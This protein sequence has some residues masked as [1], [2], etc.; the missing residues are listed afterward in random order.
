VYTEQKTAPE[1]TNKGEETMAIQFDL[2]ALSRFSNVNFGDNDAIANLGEGNGLVQNEKL[3]FI[4][5]RKFRSAVAERQNNAVRTELLKSLGRAFNLTG[6]NEANGTF[7]DQFMRRLEEILGRDT[8]KRGD[9]GIKNGVVDSGKPLTQRRIQAVYNA[10]KTY[11]A[12]VKFQDVSL[13]LGGAK[14]ADIV[15]GDLTDAGKEGVK[16]LALLAAKIRDA[17]Q[18]L[19]NEGNSI[20]VEQGN[21]MVNLALENGLIK[22]SAKIGDAEAKNV[23]NFAKT[24]DDLVQTM[25]DTI[26]ALYDSFPGAV[27]GE[28]PY[29]RNA[30]WDIVD[31][32]EKS[33]SREDLNSG[34]DCRLREF[35]GGLLKTKAGITE[36]EIAKLTNDDLATLSKK[37]LNTGDADGVRNDAAGYVRRNVLL[38]DQSAFFRGG[39]IG[40]TAGDKQ[41]AGWKDKANEFASLAVE[42]REAA[43]KMTG[44]GESEWIVHDDFSFR[45]TWDN[46][47][48][49]VSLNVDGNRRTVG[50]LGNSPDEL[51]KAMDDAIAGLCDSPEERSVLAETVLESYKEL[52]DDKMDATANCPLRRF[53]G[54]LLMSKAGFAEDQIKMFTNAELAGLV[55][56]LCEKG[57]VEEVRN[58]AKAKHEKTSQEVSALL[59]GRKIDE[60]VSDKDNPG[61][62]SKVKNLAVLAGNINAAAQRLHK[63]GGTAVAE[64]L[65]VKVELTWGEAGVTAKTTVGGVAQSVE[66]F[67]SKPEDVCDA[68]EGTIFALYDSFPK[69]VPGHDIGPL[70]ARRRN[71]RHGKVNVAG[72]I[73]LEY[74]LPPQ[75]LRRRNPDVE[76]RRHDGAGRQSHEQTA[77]RLRQGALQVRRCAGGQRRHRLCHGNQGRACRGHQGRACRGQQGCRIQ[78]PCTRDPRRPGQSPGR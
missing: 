5:T 78:K 57:D 53:A 44:R 38:D 66:N 52:S 15:G 23:E 48:M 60:I 22:A 59:G 54:G 35:A 1:T 50:N 68:M 4:L 58:E 70:G 36:A 16:H 37:L 18:S 51:C 17:A 9:F 11:A 7:T 49:K 20:S 69:G 10:A 47:G 3:G 74:R 39:K 12:N 72:G 29:G 43:Q 21:V 42:V 33:M 2:N 41:D 31:A 28:R 65:G 76:G 6:F 63:K 13:L 27:Q 32:Y 24:K 73:R 30:M 64:H 19:E 62:A 45:L 67:A 61:H 75:G 40:E 56:K 25:D 46:N 8:F 71:E 14:I 55:Q 34:N 77:L 26:S